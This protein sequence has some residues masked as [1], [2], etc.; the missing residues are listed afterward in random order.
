ME[1]L[2]SVIV[3]VHNTAALLPRC[4]DSLLRQDHKNIE[5]ILIDDGSS[6][7][8]DAL[9]TGYANEYENIAAIL[10]ENCGVSAARNAGL[11]RARGQYIGFVDSDDWIEPDMYSALLEALVKHGAEIAACSYA[12]HRHDGVI[13]DNMVEPATPQCLE[14][15]QALESLIHPRGIQGF[16]CNKLFSRKLLAR[17]GGAGLMKL[18]E[19][20]HVCE[21]LL[22]VSRCI[23]EAA[24]VAY[25]CRPMYIYCVRDYGKVESYNHEKR[26]SELIALDRL[27]ESWSC[28]SQDL[29]SYLKLKYTFDAYSILRAAASAKDK[30][31]LPALRMR[32]RRYLGEYLSSGSVRLRLKMRVLLTLMLP[33]L[34]NRIVKAARGNRLF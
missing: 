19:E 8:S 31:C 2:I 15:V 13:F 1:T 9:C 22:Y 6:D 34:E 3:P 27:V 20:I 24:R 4:V 10:Q 30:E 32:L 21:D 14:K 5:I 28:L 23:E 29:G 17:I 26:V 7:G 33:N 12:I 25:D 16:L 11:A 18:D